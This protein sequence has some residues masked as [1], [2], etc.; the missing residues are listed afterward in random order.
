[1]EQGAALSRGGYDGR[2]F[3]LM[4]AIADVLEADHGWSLEQSDA[5]L[6]RMGLWQE[7]F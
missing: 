7:E 1:L 4:F 2:S 6:E 3:D 5:W